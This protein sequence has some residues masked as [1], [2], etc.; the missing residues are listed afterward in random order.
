MPD[1]RLI[2]ARDALR[3]RFKWTTPPDGLAWRLAALL[4]D[5]AEAWL[6][7]TTQVGQRPQGFTPAYSGTVVAITETTVTWIE[8][9]DIPGRG[10]AWTDT[11][12]TTRTRSL[13]HVVSVQTQ[14]EP[15]LNTDAIEDE[16]GDM[17]TF[18]P[19]WVTVTF[20]DGEILRLPLGYRPTH[21]DLPVVLRR[22]TNA[23]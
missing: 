22:I 18:E 6:D 17:P 8:F 19:G 9:K 21:A 14:T 4:N 12:I 10:E 15:H 1:E 7:G 23:M 16:E 2:K 13:R 11:S 20:N 5:P 3:A